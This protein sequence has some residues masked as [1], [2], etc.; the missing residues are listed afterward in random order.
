[1]TLEPCSHQGKTP[2]C[3]EAIITAGIAEVVYAAED[4]NP[5]ARGGA[6]VL[7]AAGIR[8]R[9]GVERAA[10][11]SL[12]AP[13]FRAYEAGT[14]FVTLKLALSL[15]GRIAA[16]QGVRSP[17]TGPAANLEVQRQ[18]AGND[19]VVVGLGTVVADDPLLTVR[20]VPVRVQPVRV[21]LDTEARLPAASK[22]A[23][24]ANEAPVC[25]VC[26]PDAE[27]RRVEQL[28]AAGVRVLRA[29]RAAG[30]LSPA[31]AI[32]ALGEAGMQALFVEGGARLATSLLGASLV[33]RMHLYIA[34]FFFGAAGVP[35]FALASGLDGWA[36]TNST[37]L[38]GD[39]LMTLERTQAG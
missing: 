27:P 32:R 4:P 25:V 36:F 19:A 22:L 15:D 13:F 30:G 26:A 35:A 24:T 6:D 1:V 31:S 11:R 16:R 14:P 17:V 39:A 21:V 5:R 2:P 20:D 33:D 7:R 38:G 9:A 3:T 23:T 12:N 18:R 8:V 29:A 28:E 37:L 34:P 10:A